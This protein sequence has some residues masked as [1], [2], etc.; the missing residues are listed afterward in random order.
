M[1]DIIEK[2]RNIILCSCKNKTAVNYLK[3]ALEVD[4][5]LDDYLGNFVC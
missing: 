5:A 3:S 1:F 2:N 4:A